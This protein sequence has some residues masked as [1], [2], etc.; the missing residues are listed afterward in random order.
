MLKSQKAFM[1][2][3]VMLSIFI[4]V[5]GVVFVISSYMTSIKA[6]KVS[7]S[8]LDALYLMEE[9]MWEYD[10]SGEVEE[11]NESGEFEDYKDAEWSTEAQEMEDL[12][13]NETI[14]EVTLKK[15][16]RK[17]KFA[18]TTYFYNEESVKD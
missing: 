5:V 12:P 7:R 10:E 11:G 9:K 6:F 8:Y 3:E 2:L 1:L 14:V 13:L 15:G 16:G 17:R 18:V 4:V